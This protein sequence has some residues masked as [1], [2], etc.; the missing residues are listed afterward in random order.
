MELSQSFTRRLKTSRSLVFENIMDLD[1]VCV[2]HRRWFKNLRVRTWRPDYVDYQLSSNFYGLK[3]EVH[4]RG[5]PINRD[6][7]WYEFN[8]PMARIRVDGEMEGPDGDLLLTETIT[9]NFAWPLAPLFWLLRPLFNIQKKDILRDDSSLLERVYQFEQDGLRRS[10]GMGSLPKVVVYGGS[11]FFGRCVVQDL[12]K[13][14]DAQIV[15]ASRNPNANHFVGFGN[16]VHCYISDSANRESVLA[17]LHDAKVLINCTGPYQGMG[18]DL[19]EACILKRVH[20]I[21]VADDRDFVERA[22]RLKPQV[23]AAGIKALIGCS[24]VPGLSALLTRRC[25]EELGGLDTVRIF[26]TPGTRF[27]RGVGSFECL[28]A[29][30]GKR[31]DVPRQGGKETIIGWTAPET[32]EFPPPIGTRNVYSVVDIADYF[33]QVE[34]FG[35]EAVEFKIGSEFNWLNKGLTAIRESK[36]RLRLSSLRPLMPV[37]RSLVMLASLIGTSQGAMMVEVTRGRGSKQ[38]KMKLAVYRETDGQVIP[39][40]L[41]AI[42]AKNILSGEVLPVGIPNLAEWI[43]TDRLFRELTNRGV[44]VASFKKTWL[45]ASA[46][47]DTRVKESLEVAT[48]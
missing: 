40:L 1:H 31:F 20:Y 24:V 8:G 19:L 3:Q 14:S 34:L 41:P 4:V 11:G 26:I 5:A 43:S 7:Y 35:A 6:R 23:E 39:A 22:Y 17:L 38:R 32:V 42:A 15:V 18:L 10:E 12:L 25:V 36:T 30:V 48:R 13:F 16:R 37:F 27:T 9:F 47:C 2:L 28:L 44:S 29:T 21:D 33:T 45:P 46:D